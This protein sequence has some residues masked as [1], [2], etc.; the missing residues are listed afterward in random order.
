MHVYDYNLWFPEERILDEEVW[1]RIQKK[2]ETGCMQGEKLIA[3]FWL[4]WTLIWTVIKIIKKDKKGINYGERMTSVSNKY[5]LD[6]QALI[7]VMMQKEHF[8]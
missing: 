4:T 6:H 1:D 5:I 3:H 2:F 8:P 7:L